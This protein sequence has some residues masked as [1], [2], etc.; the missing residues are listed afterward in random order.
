MFNTCYAKFPPLKYHW[1]AVSRGERG[2]WWPTFLQQIRDLP[3]GQPW[4][5]N[6]AGDLPGWGD[7]IDRPMLNQLVTANTGRRGWTY[8][9][10]PI[11]TVADSAAINRANQS[12]FTINLS[13]DTLA[14]ADNLSEWKCGPVVVVVPRG[15]PRTS[16][17]PAGRKIVLCPAQY[18]AGV[19]CESCLLCQ[20]AD[21][22]VIVGF[23]AHGT[24]AK[25]AEAICRS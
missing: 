11:L 16:Y 22:S 19:T 12:G 21:R 1:Q 2:S 17:T 7:T 25:R 24:A 3:D 23:V 13:A 20:R 10:K 14:E 18:R 6:Q 9:H 4:R 15:T 8:T 5:H